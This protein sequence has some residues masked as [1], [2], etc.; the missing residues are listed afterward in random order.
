MAEKIV[1]NTQQKIK[2]KVNI[3]TKHINSI[4]AILTDFIERNAELHLL[5][6]LS[7]SFDFGRSS[8]RSSHSRH[9][10]NSSFLRCNV[11]FQLSL[12][13]QIFKSKRRRFSKYGATNGRSRQ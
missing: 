13:W 3:N 9:R 11:P 8:R 6:P 1:K 5:V 4:L 2:S 12:Y 7:S 10:G